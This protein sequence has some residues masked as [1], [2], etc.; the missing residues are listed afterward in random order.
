MVDLTQITAKDLYDYRNFWSY[1]MLEMQRAEN[2]GCALCDCQAKQFHKEYMNYLLECGKLEG[3]S[4]TKIK[5]QRIAILDAIKVAL[6]VCSEISE[7]DELSAYYL[8]ESAIYT[9]T[10]QLD[11]DIK[12]YQ[13]LVDREFDKVVSNNALSVALQRARVDYEYLESCYNR[14]KFLYLRMFGTCYADDARTK[15]PERLPYR[16]RIKAIKNKRD[17]MQQVKSD[18]VKYYNQNFNKR[19]EERRKQLQNQ[20]GTN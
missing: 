2:N 15:D 12:I 10:E 20:P 5:R 11:V 19:L 17:E 4:G 13:E 9:V 16:A 6:H 8:L 18:I 1:L 3:F 14:H 7:S